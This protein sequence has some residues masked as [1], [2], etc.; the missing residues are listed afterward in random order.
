MFLFGEV[1]HDVVPGGREGR[2]EL[3]KKKKTRWL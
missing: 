1:A 2:S 3:R